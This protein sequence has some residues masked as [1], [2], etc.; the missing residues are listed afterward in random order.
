MREI[1]LQDISGFRIGSA[2]NVDAAT[3]CTIIICPTGAPCSVDIRG[4]GPASRETELLNPVAAA[5]FVHAVVLSGG[6]AYGL[7][8]AD[9]VMRYLEEHDIGLP[10]GDALVPLVVASCIFDLECGKNVRPDAAMGY[11][12]CVAAE[13][14]LPLV[15][16]NYG[17]G[18]GATVGK[19]LGEEWMMKAGLGTYALAVGD[20][21][22]GAVVAVNALG[23]V[24]DEEGK[25][26]CG[27][28]DPSGGG[29][30]DTRK[31]L[32][33]KGEALAQIMQGA[34]TNT[35]I[36]AVIT[37]GKFNKAQLKKIAA[38]ASNGMVRAVCPVNTTA[39]GDAIYA[40]S[41]GEVA[42]DLDYTGVLAAYAVE[43][44]IRRAVRA[45]ETAYGV[46]ALDQF[47]K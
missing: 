43:Q 39:D 38:L 27:L 25:V 35:T 36:G 7:S 20:L 21:Q 3:G 1:A 41:V 4:G 10:V 23:D 22:V 17:V 31:L 45:A 19:L 12:A 26:L 42:A 37:N 46:P 11:A 2:E 24:L 16:G 13:K 32:L 6:S 33:E 15:E 30:A 34:V 28:R 47:C 14:N 44:A 18:T 8:S 40:L 9:G 5:E 29:L